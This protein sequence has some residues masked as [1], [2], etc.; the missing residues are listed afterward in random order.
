MLGIVLIYFIGKYFYSLADLYNK[1]KWGFAI[2]GVAS[3]YVG[4]FAGVFILGFVMEIVSP[5]TLDELGDF[6]LSVMVLPLGVL[7]CWGF[8]TIL[9]RVWSRSPAFAAEEVLDADV[10]NDPRDFM[11][12]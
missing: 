7:S 2:A 12:H 5:G 4:T 9:K 10:V 3:Y 6:A 1:S 8:Y 11:N